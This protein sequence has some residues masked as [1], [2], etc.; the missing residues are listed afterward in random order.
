MRKEYLAQMFPVNFA[1]CLKTPFSKNTSGGFSWVNISFNFSFIS[2]QHYIIIYKT[3]LKNQVKIGTN[4][5][6]GKTDL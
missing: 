2:N 5:L 3:N 6:L 1:K 4:D